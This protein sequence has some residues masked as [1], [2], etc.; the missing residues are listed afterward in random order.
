MPFLE[1][2]RLALDT[3]R[4][5]KLKSFFTLLGV[6][7]GVMFLIAVISIV[8][9]MSDYVEND[10]AGKII[11]VNTYNFRRRPDFTPNETEEAWR[12]YQRR[13]LIFAPEVELVRSTIPPGSRSAILNENFRYA[14]GGQGRPRQVQAVATEADYFQIKK[15]GITS[16][17]AFTPQEVKAGSRVLV[18]GVEVAEHFFPGLD[19][20]GRELRVA[21]TPYQIIGVIE[22]QG[23]VFGF[24]MDRLAIAPW[25]TPLHR[26][27][28]PRGD[29]E[30][31]LIQAPSLELV[32]EGIE[33][34]R[35]VLRGARHLPP[36]KP[37]NFALETQ[38]SAMEF[39]RGLKSKMV[40]F[41]TALPAIGL[42][43][44]ALVIMNI[45]LVAVAERTREIGI[46][47]ALGATRADILSQFLIE[48][49][50]LS[51]IGAAIG[52]G[53]GI[54]LAKAVAA[55]TPLPAAVALWSI[56]AALALGAGVGIVA[57][58]YPA[59]RAARLDP[60]EALRQE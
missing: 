6:M 51:A 26:A 29:I 13:P 53:F 2:I 24:S 32:Y 28:R 55:F 40:V 22:K 39:F 56:F 1:A 38:D 30:S 7:I 27:I 21:G 20:V 35:E 46:R 3:I 42:I 43:V 19:P 16:G 44:G 5:Q 34:A 4:V 60:I 15:F 59:S 54:A 25:T 47:K 14:V 17:R 48:A 11:G 45:M 41:G 9:G 33:S 31:L 37:D 36:G 23:S 58:V 12:E 10:F 8:E 18:I 50:T 52:I 49:A 57:G